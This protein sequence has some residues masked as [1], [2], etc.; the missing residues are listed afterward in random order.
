MENEIN[1]IDY[2][3][4]ILKRKNLILGLILLFAILGGVL[5]FFSPR[6]YKTTTVFF[7]GRNAA[8]QLIEEPP[9]LVG[10]INSGIYGVYPG[11]EAVSL[12]GISLVEIQIES[13]NPGADR[14][15]LGKINSSIIEKHNNQLNSEKAEVEK[16][17]EKLQKDMNFLMSNNQQIM[18]LYIKSFDLQAQLERNP[19]STEVMQKPTSVLK[20][21]PSLPIAVILGGAL[22]FILGIFLVFGIEWWQ[23][24][25]SKLK[26]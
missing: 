22:G 2:I 13:K 1:L 7:I 26:R 3:K 21:K 4:I 15:A 12:D 10:E 24:N 20:K 25:K 19:S 14:A 9:L 6:V 16:Y 18:A 17:I 11:V 5:V 23:K 8:S